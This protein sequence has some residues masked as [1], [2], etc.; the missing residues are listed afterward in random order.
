V[1]T[2][3]PATARPGGRFIR[4]LARVLADPMLRNGHALIVSAGV[5]QVIGV[6]YWVVAARNYPAAVV[7]RNSAAIAITLFLAGLAELNMMSTLVRFLPASGAR[8][9][10]FVLA[11]YAAASAVAVLTGVTFWLLIPRVQPQL[12]FLRASPFL[13]V[14][15][16]ASIV[17][18]AIF[19]LQDSAL[20]G[21]R[22]A[23]FV[24]V[25]NTVFAV[26]KLA[27]M[28]P[29]VGLLPGS[30]IYV[31]WTAAF[32]LSVLPTN[33][34]LFGRAIPRHLR[35]HPAAGPPPRWAD[36][37][38]YLIPDSLAAFFFMAAT[39]LLPLM[40]IDRLGP[41]AAGHYAPA[42]LI[43]YAL[44]LVSLNMGAS[45]MVET[46]ADQSR[47]RERCLRS[48]T[49][50]ARLVV[51]VVA[52]VMLAAPCV[53]AVFGPGYAAAGTGALRLLAGSAVP[54]LLTNTA[55]NAARVRRRMAVVAGIQVCI[56][57]AVWGLS[58]LLIGPLGLT[59]VGAAWLIAQSAAAAVLIARPR[60]WLPASTVGR[61]AASA[62]A[63]GEG[64]RRPSAPEASGTALRA[65]ER[66]GKGT[67][68]RRPGG[69]REGTAMTEAGDGPLGIL[70]AP[71]RPVRSAYRESRDLR[72][73]GQ[74]VRVTAPVPTGVWAEVAAADPTT[75]PF[76]TPARTRRAVRTA[77]RH[78]E[79]EGVVISSGNSPGLVDALYEVYLRW[80]G[81]R[82]AQRKMPGALAG[83][84]A[85]RAEPP[86]KFAAVAR[87]LGQDCRIWVAWWQGRPVA[88]TV[89]LYTPAAAVGWRAFTDRAAPGRLRLFEVLAAEA[90]RDACESGRH[91]LE[92]G[93][94]VGRRDLSVIKERLGAQEHAF[95]EYCFERV[96]LAAG[97]LAVQRHRRT[98]ERWIT[99]RTGRKETS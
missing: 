4:P 80:I 66:R 28:V 59:G 65:P 18:G 72:W 24:P 15:F 9:A 38:S 81:W 69:E 19:V 79:Q 63:T 17:T 37:R 21:A 14:W 83:W 33:A 46:S 8:T 41:A 61:E 68:S 62:G 11:V 87:A 3:H 82:A 57:M 31:S 50:L 99:G 16:V 47:L 78:H 67:A 34:Y 70:T 91:Y 97:R 36:I 90:L 64:H 48:V 45:L 92:M 5:T 88:A 94:S 53:L 75:L 93:E 26:V 27:L 51:P 54:A 55:I 85:R 12:A 77:R 89:S 73:S 95:A 71:G 74:A 25:E 32:A 96:P 22:A 52:V 10:R 49:H 84:Q 42:W 56:C 98:A 13:A 35:E 60:L 6:L 30:G 2:G 1:T 39:S 86:G 29:L 40:I 76:Q 58:V 20:T 44:Y 7:G 43:G 23:P